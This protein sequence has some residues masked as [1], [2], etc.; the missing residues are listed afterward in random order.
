MKNALLKFFCKLIPT[1]KHPRNQRILVVST[2][3]LGDT[4]WATPTLESLRKSFPNAY[5]SVL[6][7]PIGKE[8]LKTNP[9]IDSIHLLAE[10]LLPR[11][12]SLWRTLIKEKFDTILLLH[13]S[14]R[15]VLPLCSLLG[16]SQI[17]GTVGINKGLDSLLTDPMPKSNEHEIVRRLKMVEKIG[18]KI[19]TEK[20][21]FSPE[22][23]SPKPEGKWV[24]IHPG[25]KDG[26]KRWP[27]KNFIEVG[28]KLRGVNL[29]ITGT[30]SE[31]PL[32][33]EIA[34]QIPGA[35]IADPTL[36]LHDFAKLL[37]SLDLLISNDTGPVH[38]A[39]ALNIPVIALYSATDPHLCGPH[40]A[41]NAK[42][43]YKKPT[44]TPCLKRKCRAPFCLQQIGSDEV[45]H[46]IERIFL[47]QRSITL[48][49]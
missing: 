35:V 49:I 21:S 42:V 14:Q 31:L 24:A 16:A 6:T 29:L 45:I 3:A 48:K 41:P 5:L 19:H 25:S 17:I 44:C 22:V 20:L 18:G 11:V 1:Q 27:A 47:T 28:K 10:P 38:L 2:T 30:E 12:F 43:F 37:S 40:K 39:C 34:S 36:S 23:P 4:L 32:M 26:F 13:A 8:V 15:L 7:S 46:C 33:Q 9:W